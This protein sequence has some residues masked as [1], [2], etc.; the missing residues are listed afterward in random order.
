[1]SIGL[2]I[3]SSP[4][5]AA[6]AS[7]EKPGRAKCQVVLLLL[8]ELRTTD[9]KARGSKPFGRTWSAGVRAF[10]LPYWVSMGLNF[11]R[12]AADRR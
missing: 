12:I 8:G 3:N 11:P 10:G 5:S 6:G 9:Q 7:T 1:L 4:L 2:S